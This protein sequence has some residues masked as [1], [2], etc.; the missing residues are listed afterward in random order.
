MINND[1]II[2]I[3]N[4]E[5]MVVLPSRVTPQGVKIE[6]GNEEFPSIT[7]LSFAEIKYIN[8]ISDTFRIGRLRFEKEIE[9]DVCDKLSITDRENIIGI[10][11]I[12][13][14][15]MDNSLDNL[16]RIAKINSLQLITRI[17][18][19]ALEMQI[20]DKAIPSQVNSVLEDRYEE[21]TYNIK[22][23]NS[24]LNNRIKAEKEEVENNQ[25]RQE[26]DELKS[27]NEKLMEQMKLMM[28]QMT[29]IQNTQVNNKN[30]EKVEEIKEDKKE[31]KPKKKNT[32]ASKNKK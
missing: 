28:E 18:Q 30:D 19:I 24:Y 23:S 6:S 7:P 13:K 14:M 10:N 12:R 3:L 29:N 5:G 32:S 26:I 11:E 22:K 20:N 21:L 16:K 2:N 17:K 9:N 4:Y 25:S 8:S 15:A 1:T 27:Q 31:D